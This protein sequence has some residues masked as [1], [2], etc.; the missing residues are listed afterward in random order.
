MVLILCQYRTIMCIRTQ[1]TPYLIFIY[2][3][4]KIFQYVYFVFSQNLQ[5]DWKF[6]WSFAS[7]L[8]SKSFLFIRNVNKDFSKK[9]RTVQEIMN[10]LQFFIP[11]ACQRLIWQKASWN[12]PWNLQ[13][14]NIKL[15]CNICSTHAQ[16]YLSK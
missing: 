10:L 6:F 15:T 16:H 2:I 1:N 14:G 11:D 4:N 9:F 5:N 13:I 12:V 7:V 3:E 8:L